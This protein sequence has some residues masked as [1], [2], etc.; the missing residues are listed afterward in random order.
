MLAR[1]FLIKSSS[2]LLVT[3]TGKKAR[4]GLISGRI[5]LFTLELLPLNDKNFTLSNLKKSC[6]MFCGRLDQNCGFHGNR[7]PPLIYNEEN[8]VSSFSRLLLIRSFLYLQVTRTCLKSRMRS[9]FRQFGPLA[10]ELFA[11]ERLKD[12]HRLILGKWCVRHASSFIFDRIN[13]HQ[14]C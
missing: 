8:D 2:K 10:T 13:H 4:T 5:R 9:I 7:K 1:S 6:I 3:R 11:L 14:S 12:S